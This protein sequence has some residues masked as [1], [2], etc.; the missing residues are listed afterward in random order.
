M[1]IKLSKTNH[2][3]ASSN[4]EQLMKCDAETET[5]HFNGMNRIFSQ[6]IKL[7]NDVLDSRIEDCHQEKWDGKFKFVKKNANLPSRID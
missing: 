1:E 6:H 7:L 3:S 5:P 2:C 4:C